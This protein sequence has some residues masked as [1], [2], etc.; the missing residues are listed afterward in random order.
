[1]S[2]PTRRSSDLVF[3][4]MLT[5]HVPFDGEDPISIG[6]KHIKDP[7][8]LLPA[9]LSAYQDVLE[10]ILA[11]SVEDRYQNAHDFI[12]DLEQIPLPSSTGAALS[13]RA[14]GRIGRSRTPASKPAVGAVQDPLWPQA[15]PRQSHTLLW[16]AI[17]LAGLALAGTAA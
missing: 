2:S 8:P 1:R 3:F 14:E 17:T 11:K 4:E 9:G 15:V 16:S 5:G 7:V 6:I 13:A 10:T 12:A